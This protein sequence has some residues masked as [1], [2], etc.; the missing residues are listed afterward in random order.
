M[1][2]AAT[3]LLGTV[4]VR[5]QPAAGAE[6]DGRLAA[7]HRL[8]SVQHRVE[9][10]QRS[11]HRRHRLDA[12]RTRRRRARATRARLGS[13]ARPSRQCWSSTVCVSRTW[14]TRGT[15][16]RCCPA[17][18]GVSPSPPVPSTGGR[19]CR[20]GASRWCRGGDRQ[21]APV[22]GDADRSDARRSSVRHRTG[23]AGATSTCSCTT[24][25]TWCSR[26]KWSPVRR[27]GGA[28]AT[29]C[30]PWARRDA[31]RYSD[32]RSLDG[33]LA[34]AR[35][36]E[37]ADGG[38]DIQPWTVLVCNE[39]L[40]RTVHV[41]TDAVTDPATPSWLRDEMRACLARTAPVVPDAH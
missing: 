24:D 28:S 31:G 2:G 11:R 37:R 23:A 8:R 10:Q 39:A 32:P 33:L 6:R 19:R 9:P 30:R 3:R 40:S 7:P 14:P 34:T 15:R 22:E 12:R 18:R 20:R 25:R 5:R 4:A 27:S 36:T 35:F 26:W 21:P 41:A 38:F 16:T 29:S 13:P 1:A 17:T